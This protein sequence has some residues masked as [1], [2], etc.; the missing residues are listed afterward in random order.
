MGKES[1]ADT[2]SQPLEGPPRTVSHSQQVGPVPQVIFANNRHIIPENLY[3]LPLRSN[4]LG[5]EAYTRINNTNPNLDRLDTSKDDISLKSP[6]SEGNG[7]EPMPVF[8]SHNASWGATT[9]NTKLREQVLREVFGPPTIYR[10]HRHGRSRNTLTRVNEADDD[11]RSALNRA[12]F[13]EV[14]NVQT[15]NKRPNLAASEILGSEPVSE[16][17]QEASSS[18]RRQS[19][20]SMTLDQLS[21]PG[22]QDFERAKTTNAETGRIPIPESRPIRRRHSGSGL[23]SRQNNVDSDKRSD[24]EYY[25]DDGY[26]GDGEDGGDEIFAMDMDSMVPPGHRTALRNDRGLSNDDPKPSAGLRYPEGNQRETQALINAPNHFTPKTTS[27]VQQLQHSD[28]PAPPANPKQAQ[29]QPDERNQLFLLLEDLTAGMVRPC[30]LDLKMGTR[31]YGID[32]D[33]KKKKSQRKKCK[34]TTSQQLGVR[35]CGMQVWNAKE[36]AVVFLDKYYGRDLKAGSEF[37]GAL[38]RFLS[39]PSYDSVPGHVSVLLEKI[40]KLEDI[41]QNLPGYRFYAS[42][43]LMLYEG[44][45]KDDPEWEK[46]GLTATAADKAKRE[47]PTIS[48]KIVDFA[49]CVTAEDELPETVP[50]P[51]HDPDGI[52][53]GYLRGIR[54]LRM[55]LQRIWTEAQNRRR[56]DWGEEYGDSAAVIPSAWR[57]D[58]PEEEDLGNVSI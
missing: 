6:A 21:S 42:S 16:R 18:S 26:G 11:R 27:D 29:L 22:F 45:A 49:N 38:T 20:V 54:S 47:N 14:S 33:D 37:Q 46:A 28:L 4:G 35:L 32:A 52:D 50:C 23:R 7:Q 56:A 10:R 57:D 39:C 30:V 41:I 8:H 31:Q 44:A 43:L 9:V 40:A 19:E 12:S 36:Q 17:N 2:K 53:R 24:L 58:G 51:P 55:Y 34:L 5:R 13:I 25:E 1:S 48:I 15:Q 3:P